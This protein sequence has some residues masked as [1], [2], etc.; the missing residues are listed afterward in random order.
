[1]STRKRTREIAAHVAWC[2]RRERA[3]TAAARRRLARPDSPIVVALALTQTLTRITAVVVA[4]N[5]VQFM[6]HQ[7]DALMVTARVLRGGDS[8][9]GIQISI[10][11]VANGGMTAAAPP[12][13]AVSVGT[14]LTIGAVNIVWVASSAA[15]KA[16]SAKGTVYVVITTFLKHATTF[17]LAVLYRKSS[18]RHL[19]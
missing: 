12:A 10:N 7:A 19:C 3:R 6:A 11:G 2:A 17:E 9:V 1:M 15:R 8:A 14:G 13:T 16:L 4:V 5:V 18:G